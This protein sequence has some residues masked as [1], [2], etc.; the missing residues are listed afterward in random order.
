[1]RASTLFPAALIVGSLAYGAGA[2][3]GTYGGTFG[4][5]GTAGGGGGS[6]DI[7]AVG[8]C[9]SGDC[10]SGAGTVILSGTVQFAGA[11]DS[12][13][14]IS[15]GG[16]A[17]CDSLAAGSVCLRDAAGTVVSSGGTT[18]MEPLVAVAPAVAGSAEVGFVVRYNE[19]TA[20][21][22]SLGNNTTSNSVATPAINTRA[23]GA[24]QPG[25]QLIGGIDAAQD[26]GTASAVTIDGRRQSG[27][28][29]ANT[30]AA[31]TTR[32]VLQV[33]SAGTALFGLH[34]NG[35]HG[36]STITPTALAAN[37]DNYAG[38]TS[39]K[40]CR[41]GMGG[42]SYNLTGL[43]PSYTA[44]LSERRTICNVDSTG[45]LTLVDDATST[46]ANRF[47]LNANFGIVPERCVDIQ[48][49]LTSS[50]WRLVGGV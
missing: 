16:S 9:T 18:T 48:Y 5:G 15:N 22:M 7:T 13:T 6:G 19:A 49:D 26:S 31:L 27:T 39:T 25:L 44:T 14:S 3:A 2:I 33:N 23:V 1:M 50:R 30:N 42:G 43:V 8:D 28:P 24:N 11:V 20:A 45:T 21:W 12:R 35:T 17:T 32:P 10:M 46:A 38:C 36:E 40:V 29:T 34:V 37:T 4:N 47:Q 41:I